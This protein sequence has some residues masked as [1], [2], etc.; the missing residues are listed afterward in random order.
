MLN[1]SLA[2]IRKKLYFHIILHKAIKATQHEH[3]SNNKKHKYWK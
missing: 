1:P 2:I 3:K